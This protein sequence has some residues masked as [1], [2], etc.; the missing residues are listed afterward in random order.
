VSGLGFVDCTGLRVIVDAVARARRSGVRF[1]VD[2]P[3][4][5]PVKRVIT[6]LDA[7]SQLWP[8]EPRLRVIDGSREDGPADSGRPRVA[9]Y[10]DW[11]VVTAV[12]R[13]R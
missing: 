10:A 12:S 3:V 7:A 5:A 8:S 11:G 6:Y 2:R 13:R 9:G 1:E 4:S